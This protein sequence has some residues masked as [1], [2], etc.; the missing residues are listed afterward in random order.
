MC[1]IDAV[2]PRSCGYATICRRA[3][4]TCRERRRGVRPGRDDRLRKS[5][6]REPPE[7]LPCLIRVPSQNA[8]RPGTGPMVARRPDEPHPVTPLELLFDLCF[9]VAVR[10][11]AHRLHHNLD[12]TDIVQGIGIY[13]VVFFAIWWAWMNFTTFASAYDPQDGVYRLTT[14]VQIAI[15]L[16]LAAGVPRAFDRGDFSVITYGYVIM[17]LAMVGQWLRRRSQRP[18]WAV[19]RPP[20]RDGSHRDAGGV[21]RPAGAARSVAAARLPGDCGGGAPA[22]V[23]GQAPQ[24]DHLAPAAH[25]R[26]VRA[27]HHHRAGR[28]GARRQPG[29]AK[30]ARRGAHRSRP[31]RYP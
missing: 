15:A 10:Q 21:D 11:A 3:R 2:I 14:L 9:V 6:N 22:A 27:V 7:V 16:V 23:L 17:R 26:A 29:R 20:L 13:P 31:H 18:A 8:S 12:V 28:I 1:P 19:H 5:S 25:H 4:G 24:A 30:G